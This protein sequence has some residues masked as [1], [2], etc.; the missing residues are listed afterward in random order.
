VLTCLGYALGIDIKRLDRKYNFIEC[1]KRD[2]ICT[3][4]RGN[5]LV[6]VDLVKG[7]W[8]IIIGDKLEVGPYGIEH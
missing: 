6:F 5:M 2:M 7:P 3:N 4:A 1:T 8:A